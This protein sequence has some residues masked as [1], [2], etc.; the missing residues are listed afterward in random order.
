MSKVVF[1]TGGAGFIGGTLIRQL[2]AESNWHIVNVDKITYA[3]NLEGLRE[4]AK[5][6]RYRFEHADICDRQAMSQLFLKFQPYGIFHLAAE[7]HVDRS[8]DGPADFVR[9]NVTGTY[10]LLESALEYWLNITVAKRDAFRFQHIST[11]EVFG[12]LGPDDRFT[13]S[14]AYAPNSPYAASKAAADH[15]V[16][17]WRKTYGLPVLISNCSNNYGPFQ[18]PEKLIPLVIRR[19]LSNRVL[20]I[21]GDGLNVR[22]WLYVV[23]HCRAL[24][25]VHERGHVGETYNVGGRAERTNLQVVHSICDLLD[26]IKPRGDGRS[27]RDQIKFVADRPGHDRRYAIDPSKIERELGWRT[28]EPFE[29]GL[30]RTVEWYL[31]NEEWCRIVEAGSYDGERLGVVRPPAQATV[32]HQPPRA[33]DDSPTSS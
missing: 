19:A 12:S 31:A 18:Y 24:R 13:E 4:V 29:S 11:D 33:P 2:M 22:D 14:T 5:S 17:A 6:N 23:D 15:L 3:G 28:T 16:R 10:V 21:Y 20:P 1:V 8:I 7:S 26:E 25:L 32:S 9:T 30:R 27:Y